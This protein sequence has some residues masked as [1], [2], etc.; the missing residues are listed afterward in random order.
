[1][2]LTYIIVCV[3]SFHIWYIHFCI[4]QIYLHIFVSF[5]KIACVGF[6]GITRNFLK[7][8]GYRLIKYRSVSKLPKLI[9]SSV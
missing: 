9:L 2:R 1:M 7:L 8:M 6:H 5:I 3:L 4:Q